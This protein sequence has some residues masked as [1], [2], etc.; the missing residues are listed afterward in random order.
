MICIPILH[1]KCPLYHYR[2]SLRQKYSP[3][4][5]NDQNHCLLNFGDSNLIPV[6]KEIDP[7][8]LEQ[9]VPFWPTY[10]NYN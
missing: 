9:L 6:W 8:C 3:K 7:R 1:E 10:N 2:P 4:M 5:L